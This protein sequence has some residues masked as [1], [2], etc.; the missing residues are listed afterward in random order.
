MADKGI[1]ETMNQCIN[2]YAKANR[3][4]KN[5]DKNTKSSYL[6]DWNVKSSYGWAMLQ[7]L[8]VNGFQCAEDIC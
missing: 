8:L 2:K 6:T 1:R 3:Y 7:K 4:M 5:Y